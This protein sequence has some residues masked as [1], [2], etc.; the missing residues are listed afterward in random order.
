M[1]SS[2]IHDMGEGAEKKS[3]AVESDLVQG[4]RKIS[5]GDSQNKRLETLTIK[6]KFHVIII[7]F[8]SCSLYV[9]PHN[10][11]QEDDK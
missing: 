8:F 2:N 5:G 7:P 10:L 9:D 6:L 3:E 4:L 1:F 11:Y